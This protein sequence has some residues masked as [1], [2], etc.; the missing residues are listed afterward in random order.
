[1]MTV[2]RISHKK[3]AG[4]LIA[5][6]IENRWNLAG[7][8]V[9]YTSTSRA[10]ACLEN[11][12]YTSG[13]TL[14][15]GLYLCVTI[16]IP[17]DASTTIISLKDL[18]DHYSTEKGKLITQSLGDKWYREKKDLLLQVP[19]VIIAEENNIVVNTLHEDFK[20]VKIISKQPF[21]FDDRLVK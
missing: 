6:G 11:L 3:Y 7:E 10:L 17:D 8:L 9:L 18:P 21:I 4:Q 5:S 14:G 12:V 19:S 1:M 16:S 2:Y 20:L 15:S 13:E